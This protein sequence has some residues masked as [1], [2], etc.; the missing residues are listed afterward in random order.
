M[1]KEN[2]LTNKRIYLYQFIEVPKAL[3]EISRL[4]VKTPM[5]KKHLFH[6]QICNNLFL[7]CRIS[8][9]S[10]SLLY[11]ARHNTYRNKNS[12]INQNFKS[13]FY[14]LLLTEKSNKYKNNL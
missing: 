9:F 8:L 2:W 6:L 10:G 7:N 1:E 5:E 11:N 3:K 14:S 13:D 4:C 12:K